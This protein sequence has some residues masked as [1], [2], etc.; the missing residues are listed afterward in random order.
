MYLNIE[1]MG[2]AA[3]LLHSPTRLQSCVTLSWCLVTSTKIV[4]YATVAFN[5]LTYI[6]KKS[7]S[8]LHDSLFYLIKVT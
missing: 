2:C 1:G 6:F 8:K 7:C 5:S 3:L 4:P